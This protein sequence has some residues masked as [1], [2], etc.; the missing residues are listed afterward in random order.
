MYKKKEIC[1]EIFNSRII[2]CLGYMLKHQKTKS[3]QIKT[4]KGKR[5]LFLLLFCRLGISGREVFYGRQGTFFQC[6]KRP[7]EKIPAKQFQ[8][9]VH[10]HRLSCMDFL[11]LDSKLRLRVTAEPQPMPLIWILLI[12]NLQQFRG[13]MG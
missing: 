4:R 1:T 7:S 12:K 6:F 10:V 2:R 3:E 13:G 11:S 5:L 8:T 9:K